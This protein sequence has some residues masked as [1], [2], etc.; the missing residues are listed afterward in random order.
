MFESPGAW[1][2]E[3]LTAARAELQK[4]NIDTARIEDAPIR[5][6][7]CH[8]TQVTANKR[9]FGLGEAAVGGIALGPVGL[10]GGLIGAG[11]VR[12]T[13]LKCGHVFQPGEGQ[14]AASRMQTS[15]TDI[16]QGR[17]YK[18]LCIPWVV[19]IAVTFPGILA[20]PQ[21]LPAGL[22]RLLGVPDWWLGVGWLAYLVLSV[23]ACLSRRRLTYFIVYTV[24]CVLLALNCVG[25][26]AFWSEFDR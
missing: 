19:T 24:L 8:S 7:H 20:G 3:A 9:G 13:C 11:H 16:S 5:C 22:Y 18:L 17:R 10:L 21:F 23:A 15:S 2:T 25:C 12:I 1:T 26:R 4:R 6:P 14:W